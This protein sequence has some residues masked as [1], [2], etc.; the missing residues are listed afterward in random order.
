MFVLV[1]RR[2]FGIVVDRFLEDAE[3]FVA[4]QV[5]ADVMVVDGAVFVGVG[6][7]HQH[8]DCDGGSGAGCEDFPALAA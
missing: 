3:L 8:G 2:P 4:C 1:E 7:F 5:V 6:V